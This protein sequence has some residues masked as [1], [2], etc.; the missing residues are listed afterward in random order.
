MRLTIAVTAEAGTGT[1]L[2][3]DATT[4]P[5]GECNSTVPL[6]QRAGHF[7]NLLRRR[8]GV[9]VAGG[10]RASGIDGEK[11]REIENLQF[12]RIFEEPPVGCQQQNM[13]AGLSKG[14]CKFSIP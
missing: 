9:L 6:I 4:R 12:L 13:T 3:N 5:S 2:S 1:N 11:E 14:N 7:W 10:I 8:T